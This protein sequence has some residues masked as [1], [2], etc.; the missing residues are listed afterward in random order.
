MTH[1]VAT[2]MS[3]GK[4]AA[5]RLRT[6]PAYPSGLP[7]TTMSFAFDGL[8]AATTSDTSMLRR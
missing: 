8:N 5:S 6:T 4:I 1:S 3:S 2:A 7:S